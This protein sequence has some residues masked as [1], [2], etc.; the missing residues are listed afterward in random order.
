MHII[1]GISVKRHL[2]FGLRAVHNMHG[3][4]T[5]VMEMDLKN[6]PASTTRGKFAPIKYAVVI[7]FAKLL[8]ALIMCVCWN[9]RA[10]KVEYT[11]IQH[12]LQKI[13]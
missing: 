11:R 2:G 10:I 1:C 8:H 12:T 7:N 4:L 6:F 3:P 5:V 13:A 9:S